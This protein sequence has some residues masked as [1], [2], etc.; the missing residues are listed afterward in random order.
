MRTSTSLG[1]LKGEGNVLDVPGCCPGFGVFPTTWTTN[2]LSSSV[3]HYSLLRGERGKGRAGRASQWPSYWPS[4]C[5]YGAWKALR[6]VSVICA[7]HVTYL[8]CCFPPSPDAFL[9][10]AQRES[11]HALK[12]KNSTAASPRPRLHIQSA[13]RE[14]TIKAF[15]TTHSSDENQ[16]AKGERLH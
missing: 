5:Y 7:S 14:E 1:C 12:K 11:K 13:K 9:R 4:H 15:V 10:T 6:E 2:F 8:V 16:R 3:T